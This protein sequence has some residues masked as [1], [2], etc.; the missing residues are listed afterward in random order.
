MGA[1]T[2]SR[3]KAGTGPMSTDLDQ[4]VIGELDGPP[5]VERVVTGDTKTLQLKTVLSYLDGVGYDFS[6]AVLELPE[7]PVPVYSEADRRVI[8]SASVAIEGNRL[9]A[10]LFIDYATPE[11][12]SIE[13]GEKLYARAFGDFDSYDCDDAD[14]DSKTDR[15]SLEFGSHVKHVLDV[16]VEWI[17]ISATPRQDRRIDPLG[18]PVP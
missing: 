15:F 1:N 13:N 7:G 3:L 5:V 12:L 6:E 10:D 9:V 14:L 18:K 8:G 16:Y 17:L 4:E 11:R 2:G